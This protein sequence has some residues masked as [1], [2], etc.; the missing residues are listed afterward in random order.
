MTIQYQGPNGYTIENPNIEDLRANMIESFPDYWH[1]GHGS[2][3]IDYSSEE[4]GQFSLIVSVDDVYGIYL[5]FCVEKGGLV[6]EE[7]LSVENPSLMDT[8]IECADEWYASAGLFLPLEKAWTGIK[9]F[10]ETG[11]RSPDIEWRNTFDMP[12]GSN[13]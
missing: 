10:F 5:K 7:W 2:A 12:E 13:W 8:H 11:E 9:Y 3:I 4:N 1:Q 6:S